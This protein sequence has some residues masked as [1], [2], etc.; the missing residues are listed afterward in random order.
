MKAHFDIVDE[1][2][3]GYLEE[4]QNGLPDEMEYIL[5]EASYE[6]TGHEGEED[7]TIPHY[8]STTFNPN[9]FL[10]GQEETNHIYDITERKSTIEMIYT[11]MELD[12]NLGDDARRWWEF[13]E[14]FDPTLALERDY[15]YYQET[16]RDPVAKPNDARHKYAIEWGMRD[17]AR[18]ILN[19]V[20]RQLELVFERLSK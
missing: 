2:F 18:P 8:M 12:L 16:G 6:A 3:T 20:G 4:L 14:N 10:S 13:S 9:L 15:A 11:G 1:T 19:T 7:G 5:R 17:A